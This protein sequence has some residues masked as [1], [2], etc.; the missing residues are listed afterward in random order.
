MP[1]SGQ[2]DA[3]NA[4]Q[5]LISDINDPNNLGVGDINY[6]VVLGGEGA[7]DSFV[8][9]GGASVRARRIGSESTGAGSTGN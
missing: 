9:I 6:W 5:K 8:K 2:T 4:W 3:G 1:G 7:V